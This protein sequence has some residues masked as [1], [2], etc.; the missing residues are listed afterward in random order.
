MPGYLL[1]H[2]GIWDECG[3]V[4]QQ[5]SGIGIELVIDMFIQSIIPK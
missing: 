4:K 2:K 5:V 3:I 1:S